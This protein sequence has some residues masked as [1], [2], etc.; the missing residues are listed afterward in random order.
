MV[1]CYNY[2]KQYCSVLTAMRTWNESLNTKS[3]LRGSAL[4]IAAINH[5]SAFIVSCVVKHNLLAFN[6]A[7]SAARDKVLVNQPAVQQPMHTL[8]Q[9]G[10]DPTFH[11][12]YC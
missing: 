1:T 8:A 7:V 3:R 11:G 9:G 2:M 10:T 6:G 12:Q 5:C 4:P